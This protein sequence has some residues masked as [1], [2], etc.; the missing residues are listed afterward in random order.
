MHFPDSFT[1]WGWQRD[2]VLDNDI[3]LYSL[4]IALSGQFLD[5]T[6]HVPFTSSFPPP[7]VCAAIVVPEA[8]Q[9]KCTL[10]A[11]GEAEIEKALPADMI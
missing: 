9:T 11:C 8:T 1:D 5:D 6:W 7:L 10:Q 2:V 3:N 4:S